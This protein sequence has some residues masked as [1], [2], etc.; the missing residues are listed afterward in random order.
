MSKR[1]KLKGLSGEKE[2]WEYFTIHHSPYGSLWALSNGH[3]TVHD[4]KCAYILSNRR[5]VQV[6]LHLSS[7][8]TVG[9]RIRIVGRPC[10]CQQQQSISYT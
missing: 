9:I 4:E 10:Q 2:E 8:Y 6:S 1:W 5:R 7:L 3:Q